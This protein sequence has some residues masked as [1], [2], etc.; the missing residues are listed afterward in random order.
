MAKYC[1]LGGINTNQP[2]VF[3]NVDV[4]PEDF[5]KLLDA[6]YIKIKTSDDAPPSIEPLMGYCAEEQCAWWDE[7][8]QKCEVAVVPPRR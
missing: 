3:K 7:E 1:P 5:P 6:K 4:S 2:L 8:R